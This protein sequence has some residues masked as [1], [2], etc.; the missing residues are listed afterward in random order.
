MEPVSLFSFRSSIASPHAVCMFVP[1][2]RRVDIF[3]RR[4][5]ESLPVSEGDRARKNIDTSGFH[6]YMIT[7]PRRLI[8]R[9][10]AVCTKTTEAI[11]Y[12][13]A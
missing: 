3:H 8:P 7:F 2:T 1:A 9:E 5:N 11:T 10:Y 6:I 13:G 12:R 4:L